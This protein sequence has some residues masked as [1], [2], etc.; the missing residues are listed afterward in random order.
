MGSLHETNPSLWVA[1]S[2]EGSTGAQLPA[3]ADVVV[4]GAG[5]TGLTTAR[6]L[7]RDGAEVV[8][9]DAGSLCAGATGYTTAKLTALQRTTLS[10]IA[11]RHGSEEAAVYATAN[12]AAVEQV[13]TLATDDGI[14]C[15]F[16]RA[17][18]CTYTALDGEVGAIEAEHEAAR[19]A[20]LS[21]R[22]DAVSDL[23]FPVR[24]AVWLDGQARFHPRRYCLGLGDA[25]TRAGGAIVDHVRAL[26]VEESSSGAVV[27]TDRG[28]VAGDHVVLATHLPFVRSGAYFARAHPDRSYAMAARIAGTPPQGMYI[29]VESPTRSIRSHGDLLIVGGEG[30]KTGHDD[31]TR[32]RYA[33]L[34]SWARGHFE[35][36]EISHRW[37]AQDFETVDGLPYI[38]RL[39]ARHHRTWVATGFRKWGMTNGTVAAMVLADLIA[40]RAN[41]WAATFDSTR[42]APR[43]SISSLVRENVDVAKRFVVDRVRS[44]QGPTCTHLGCRLVRNTAEATWDCPCHGSRFDALGRVLSGPATADIV[45]IET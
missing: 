23:P 21:T 22:L 42:R 36:T 24:A 39:T 15:D 31:D 32:R 12:V 1:T 20:G 14:D 34:E 33:A 8:V 5:I 6:L 19:A 7:A 10:E 28:V 30:H 26:G 41:P 3:R 40:G 44:S 43:T 16:E 11:D 37:S 27:H 45:E 13:A 17:S 38:G 35:V 9:V 2:P 25:V 18:A 4:V 29:S